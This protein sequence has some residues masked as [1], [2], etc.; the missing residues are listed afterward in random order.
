ME[1]HLQCGLAG[2]AL[3][4]CQR[5]YE[6]A[7]HAHSL[8]ISSQTEI[9]TN[10]MIGVSFKGLPCN[11]ALCI[12]AINP[13][14]RTASSAGSLCHCQKKQTISFVCNGAISSSSSAMTWLLLTIAF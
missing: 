6:A 13:K 11:I 2:H 8:A 3:Q 5:Q 9:L 4:C 12:G 10:T 14:L 7:V 1:T